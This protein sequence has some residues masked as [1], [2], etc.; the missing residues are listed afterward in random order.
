MNDR[1]VFLVMEPLDGGQKT[2]T[3]VQGPNEEEVFENLR[4]SPSGRPYRAT[5]VVLTYSDAGVSSKAMVKVLP[6]KPV[7]DSA[8]R[9]GS[10]SLPDLP[11]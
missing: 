11:V 5:M 1:L 8:V 9:L 10:G 2:V 4:M 7:G 3:S 6:E